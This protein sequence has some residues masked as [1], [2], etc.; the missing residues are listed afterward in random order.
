MSRSPSV[1][2]RKGCQGFS[3]PP[4]PPSCS[5]PPVG[6]QVLAV[7]WDEG[8]VLTSMPGFPGGPS[9]PG[10]PGSPL[11]PWRRKRPRCELERDPPGG[12]RQ[13]GGSGG[14][15]G[16]SPESRGLQAS[17]CHPGEKEEGCQ[18]G[19]SPYRA[20]PHRGGCSGP[21]L[22]LPNPAQGSRGQ[23]GDGGEKREGFGAV[24]GY[25]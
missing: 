18:W 19:L 8:W 16:Y 22:R 25:K 1:L 10:A 3:T 23:D 21:A 11:A 4:A 5:P 17:L 14:T 9:G 7:L 12:E 24:L 15:H 2:P 13:P 20:G 6:P